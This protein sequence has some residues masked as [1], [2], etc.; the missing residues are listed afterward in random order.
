MRRPALWA[1][2]SIVTLAWLAKPAR[3]G[4]ADELGLSPFWDWKTL[5]SENFRVSFPAELEEVA[6]KATHHLEDAHSLLSPKL[7]WKPSLKTQVLVI[8]N[9][10]LANGLTASQ[11]RLGLVLWAT[12]P[13]PWFSTAYYDDWLRLLA[14]HEY[15]HFLNMDNTQDWYVPIRYLFG[16]VALPNA[17][18]PTWML[19]GLAVYMETRYTRG[20]RGRSP[21]YEM[22]LRSAVDENLLDSDE[23]YTLDRF[24]GD[25]PYSPAGEA[26]YFFGYQL[27]NQAARQARPAPGALMT[28]DE[29]GMIQPGPVS[30][31]S[32]GALGTMSLRSARRI[33]YFING[34]LENIL[35]LDWYQL[36]ESWV[37]ESRARAASQLS[38]IR[39]KPVTKMTLLSPSGQRDAGLSALGPTP[40]TDGRWLA[41]TSDTPSRRS[42]LYLLDLKSGKSRRLDD[43][44]MGATA[45]FTPD[46]RT[47]IYSAVE[48]RR[49]YYELSELEA[50]DIELDKNYELSSGL[51][52]RDPD[53][54]PDGKWVTFTITENQATSLA[55]AP[56]EQEA[57]SGRL[58]LGEVRKLGSTAAKYDRVATPRFSRD[59]G[60]IYYSIHRNGKV[61]EEL[62]SWTVA[63]G[64][65]TSLVADGKFNRYPA[66]SQNGDVYFVSDRTGVDNLYRLNADSAPELVTNVTS[67]LSTP[68]VGPSGE[69]YASVYASRGWSVARLENLQKS[70]ASSLNAVELTI[71]PPPAPPYAEADTPASHAASSAQLSDYSIFP[72]LLPRQWRILPQPLPGGAYFQATAIGFDAIDRHE[73]A[74][75][76]GYNTEVSKL[77]WSASYANRRLGPT[78]SLLG[79][80][81]TSGY[82]L[83][84]LGVTDYTRKHQY[85]VQISLPITRTYSRLTPVFGVGAEQ[86]FTHIIGSDPSNDDIAGISPFVPTADAALYFSDAETSRLSVAP[87]GGRSLSGGVRVYSNTSNLQRTWKG[88]FKGTQYLGLWRHSV[89]MPSFKAMMTSAFD[90]SYRDADASVEGREVE[91]IPATSEPLFNAFRIRGYPGKLFTARR[92]LAVGALDLRV[93]LIPVFRGIGTYPL[94]FNQLYAFAF[95]EATY[96]PSSRASITLPSA[97]VGFTLTTHLLLHIPLNLTIEYDHGF[98]PEFGGKGD[99]FVALSLGSLSI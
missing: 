41:Y 99:A 52:A 76:L 89:L 98:R 70:R 45:A 67:G 14:I 78:I 42:G 61:G 9:A 21:Q 32:E 80:Q 91:L 1:V 53:V 44:A 79:S 39:S 92:E 25:A 94:Y 28:A 87:E 23:F 34:N 66:P 54:S 62:A 86:I 60:R 97:G 68:A 27:L 16:D 48:R 64:K 40:S 30:H 59:G 71:D 8:D 29:A 20:G 82:A 96:F 7:Y 81:H 63:S 24:N 10:D 84:N 73:Y 11:L 2:L 72:S 55:L 65:I 75:G 33:P 47:L 95:A 38:Q 43:K 56:L 36:W 4:L 83:D 22:I 31:P 26:P 35:G 19:E 37:E 18:W 5:E 51:R 3:A 13:D 85:G 46:S 88:A 57:G 12:P 49:L 93:P 69:I 17:A 77:D 15:T 74:V 6:R 58:R 50:Y 90:S